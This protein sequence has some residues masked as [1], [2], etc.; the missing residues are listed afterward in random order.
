MNQHEKIILFETCKSKGELV[1][2][3]HTEKYKKLAMKDHLKAWE[4]IVE[5]GLDY[6]YLAWHYNITKKIEDAKAHLNG[7]SAYGK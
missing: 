6:E 3:L 4:E 7:G 5:S 2:L 1:G